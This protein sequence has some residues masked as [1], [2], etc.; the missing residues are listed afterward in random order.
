MQNMILRRDQERTPRSVRF[1][2]LLSLPIHG[3]SVSHERCHSLL[4]D[5]LG[6]P[7][8]TSNGRHYVSLRCMLIALAQQS[9]STGAD[10]PARCVGTHVEPAAVVPSSV[11]GTSSTA[12]KR[13]D[14]C[15]TVCPI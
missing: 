2:S 3:C 8:M 10:L 4:L 1:S 9:G 7:V 14:R 6:Q 13:G 12:S 15:L 5:Y 11:E